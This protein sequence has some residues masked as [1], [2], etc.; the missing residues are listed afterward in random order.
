M[1]SWLAR[2]R[3]RIARID[4]EAETL[5]RDLGDRAYPEARRREREASSDQIAKDWGRVAL[6]VAR[7]T[8]KRIGL[9]TATRMALEAD[10]PLEPHQAEPPHQPPE[11]TDPLDELMW[12]VSEAPSI[13]YRLQFLGAGTDRGPSIL[14]EVELSAYDPCGAVREAARLRWP[15]RAIGF[16]LIDDEGREVFGRDR[17]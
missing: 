11:K 6:A 16:R 13:P 15:R 2:R 4:A 12:I 3:A 8:G 9:D 7:K 5:I 14:K 10:F 1:L 17:R